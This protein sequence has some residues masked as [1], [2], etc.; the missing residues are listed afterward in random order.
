MS[1]QEQEKQTTQRHVSL[2]CGWQCVIKLYWKICGQ[3][4]ADSEVLLK[5]ALLIRKGSWKTSSTV[6]PLNGGF[7]E[8]ITDNK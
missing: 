5:K 4:T 7:S 6:I 8:N 1:L 3:K 2:Y